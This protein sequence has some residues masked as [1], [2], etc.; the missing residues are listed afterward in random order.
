MIS[1]NESENSWASNKPFPSSD[2]LLSAEWHTLS[3][4]DNQSHGHIR[5][6]FVAY[7]RAYGL[8]SQPERIT[9]VS[10]VSHLQPPLTSG[11]LTHTKS[12]GGASY[13]INTSSS[14]SLFNKSL[15]ALIVLLVSCCWLGML[16]FVVLS[17][18]VM[19]NK[20]I[21]TGASIRY[22]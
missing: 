19:A 17:T 7:H 11:K 18:D 20:L 6:V 14:A 15:R 12:Y 2:H 9:F 13:P 22:G 8:C 16:R 4:H 10:A 3:S 21:G 1:V 5:S